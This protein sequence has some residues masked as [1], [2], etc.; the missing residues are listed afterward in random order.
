MAGLA[1]TSV[2]APTILT[3]DDG[4]PGSKIEKGP[5]NVQLQN[6]WPHKG[7]RCSCYIVRRNM[8]TT[9][10]LTEIYDLTK[11]CQ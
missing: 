5:E 10:Q 2:K 7:I 3:E 8:R 11:P 1:S 9:K 4:V 6:S